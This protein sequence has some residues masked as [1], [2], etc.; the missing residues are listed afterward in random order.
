MTG[1][2]AIIASHGNGYH[3]ETYEPY[4]EHLYHLLKDQLNLTISSIWSADQAAQGTS[5]ILNDDILANDPH[6]FDH[7]RDVLLMV[8]TFR[9][10]MRRP[11]VGIGHSM[12]SSQA[13]ATAHFHPRL[14]ESLVL[15]EP[16]MTRYRVPSTPAMMKAILKKRDTFA[17]R[18]E[19]ETY[20]RNDP[21]YKRWQPEVIQRYIDTAFRIVPSPAEKARV[22]K[23]KTTPAVEART[24]ARPNPEWIAVGQP[25]SEAQRYTHPDVDPHAPL[26]GPMYNPGSRQTWPFLA[27][28][29]PT[30]LYL[31]GRGS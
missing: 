4:F 13:V 8:N 19:A 23:L 15:I 1:D 12:G 14:F 17:T 30:L 5:A 20:I 24:L 11:I 28:L 26:T 2:L 7:S 21:I 29:R 27:T 10:H 3:K 6:W 22:V 18:T 9:Q 25:V 31:L 16:S